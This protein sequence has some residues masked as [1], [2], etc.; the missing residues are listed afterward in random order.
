MITRA[1]RIRVAAYVIRPRPQPELLIF[2]HLG[3]PEAGQQ[4]PAGRVQSGEDPTQAVLREVI[5]ETGLKES[6]SFA[7]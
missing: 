4:V 2:E 6:P 5:E 3:V 7:P 1:P